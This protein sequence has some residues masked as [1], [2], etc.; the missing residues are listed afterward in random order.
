MRVAET[1]VLAWFALALV[2]GAL[3]AL[4][5]WRWSRRGT[6]GRE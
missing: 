1:I 6:R 2:A 3:W 4:A 5:G